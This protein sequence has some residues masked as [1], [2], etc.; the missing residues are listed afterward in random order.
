M[1][2][3]EVAFEPELGFYPNYSF[4]VGDINGDGRKEVAGLTPDGNLLRVVRLDG[5]VILERRL[6]NYSSWGSLS[7]LLLDVD[8]DGRKE[9]IT[10]DGP[11]G[12]AKLIAVNAENQVVRQLRL[13]NKEGDDYGNA[14]PTLGQ[15]RRDSP[16]HIGI[17]V[18][19]AGGQLVALDRSFR[20]LW[21]LKNL[22]HDFGHEFFS[23]DINGDGGDEI[24]ISTVDR[25]NHYGPDVNGSLIGVSH[26]GN[27]LFRIPV[28]QIA[29]AT[30]FDDV[31]VADVRGIGQKEILVEKGI[32]FNLRGDI[33][34]DVS[35]TL[36]HGQWIATAPNPHGPGLCSFISELWGT[37]GKS[38]LLSPLG[39]VIWELGRDRHTRLPRRLEGDYQVLPT[40]AH[41]IDW[42]HTGDYE[43]VLGEQLTGPTGHDC[44][45]EISQPLK[46]FFFNLQGEL[47]A[48]LPF[49]DT[50]YCGFWYSGEVHS[51]VADMDGD[52][53]PE[54]VFPR[55][56][57]HVM[58]IKKLA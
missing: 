36:D 50:R 1:S 39:E 43:I 41:A 28:R 15:F 27:P 11:P 8:R 19:V 29:D 6:Y 26:N 34:W 46:L 52:G 21:T 49:T 58:I 40:R 32:L 2:R 23:T 35:D 44:Q 30:H 42:F 16:G 51:R 33:M 14:L 56:D 47:L 5:T 3:Y 20:V 10:S 22:R 45:E 53:Q 13:E 4:E 38:K 12:N 17:S 25:I 54:W 57:G 9:I 7:I 37:E 55:Q 31:V 48:E 24:V 18:A